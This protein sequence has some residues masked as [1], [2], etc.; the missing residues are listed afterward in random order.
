MYYR[1]IDRSHGSVRIIH[2]ERNYSKVTRNNRVTST[3]AAARFIIQISDDGPNS[4]A[5]KFI[6][7]GK[8]NVRCQSEAAP[9]CLLHGPFVFSPV[10]PVEK[11]RFVSSASLSFGK[12]FQNI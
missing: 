4:T 6:T 11:W 2:C 10:K 12:A 9:M 1:A 5:I 7:E 3:Y 8:I